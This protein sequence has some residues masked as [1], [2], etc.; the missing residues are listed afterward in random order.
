MDEIQESAV[1]TEALEEQAT[2]KKREVGNREFI[3][4]LTATFFYT[5]MTGM[6]GSYR[7]EYLSFAFA[8]FG[9]AAADYISTINAIVN[10]S[11][12][13]ISFVVS[14]IIDRS[15]SKY[16]KFRPLAF[17][18]SIPMAILLV[19]SFYM[20]N[21]LYGKANVMIIY[22]CA[23]FFVYNIAASLS[24]TVNMA[25]LV[26]ANDTKERDAL[27]NWRS[28]L[29]AVGNSAPMLIILVISAII[30]PESID[31]NLS[32]YLISAI[33]C[34]AV[35]V[36]TMLIGIKTIR[37]RATYNERRENP[38]KNI[39][40]VLKNRNARLVMLS[41]F[42]KSFRGIANYMM[43][44]LA[45]VYFGRTGRTLYFGI[46]T[47]IGTFVGMFIIKYLMK[48]FEKRTLY[49]A[50]GCYSF[51]ANVLAFLAGYL[52]F[53]NP[54]N[55]FLTVVF[56][57]FMFLIGLQF[58]ASN[59]L[60]SLFGADI[61][62]QIEAKTGE[63]TDASYGWVVGLG[64][65]ISGI[66]ASSVA[67][68]LL[69]GSNSLIGYIVIEE[70]VVYSLQTKLW[71]LAFYTIFH[72]ICMLAAG[73]PFLFYDLNGKRRNDIHEAVMEQ[74]RARETEQNA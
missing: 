19:I 30:N 5:T 35:G 32:M 61:L 72:G 53:S 44:F 63:R 33:L 15:R 2:Q 42:L 34:A 65:A 29:N 49:I 6:V 71:M 27:I 31:E 26:M 38:L 54:E 50:S 52:S 60:P 36:A 74:R 3:L 28:I 9:D 22:F 18:F 41:E 68:K 46:C 51:C 57:F 67:P 45:I 25:A 56:F 20:P 73:I 69:M 62:E 66:I 14:M 10:S 23:V 55:K 58:G 4:F 39:G 11:N 40:E 7:Q 47:G 64:G 1:A 12:Y 16:G 59:L 48:K 17:I 70:G 43:A 13:I 8:S 21:F 37:E 24:G